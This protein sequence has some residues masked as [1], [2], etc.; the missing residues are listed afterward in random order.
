M[1][2]LTLLSVLVLLTALYFSL[3]D[4]T[5]TTSS[6]LQLTHGQSI[7][8]ITADQYRS[9]C[10]TY[11]T[12]SQ[13]EGPYF[14]DVELNRSSIAIN[15]TTGQPLPGVPLNLTLTVYNATET[16][17]DLLS[18]VQVDVWHA[19]AFGVY[20]DEAAENTTGQRWLR[21]YQVSD[22]NGIVRFYTIWPGPYTGRTPH[23]HVQ[24]RTYAND[25]LLGNPN[26]T[27][28]Y[29]DTTQIYFNDSLNTALF[30]AA[31]PYNISTNSGRNFTTNEEDA[32][33]SPLLIAED[34]R[35]TSNFTSCTASFKLGIPFISQ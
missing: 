10:S 26:A 2:Q 21:G 6:V 25:T 22:V 19:N 11:G 24:V 8:D 34:A 13:T 33:F 20:S 15:D 1:N 30:A 29:M 28:I 14:V 27:T 18:D 23:I 5:P 35:C 17:C 31:S 3:R 9:N 4:S 16:G 12:R 7:D 32:I